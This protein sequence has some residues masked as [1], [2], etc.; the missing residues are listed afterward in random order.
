MCYCTTITAAAACIKLVLINCL[1]TVHDASANSGIRSASYSAHTVLNDLMYSKYKVFPTS[2]ASNAIWNLRSHISYC[3]GNCWCIWFG[4]DC[5]Q[6][7]SYVIIVTVLCEHGDPIVKKQTL[8]SSFLPLF[9]VRLRSIR[10]V[11]LSRF[12]LSVCPS[13]K[14]VYCDKT[15]AP[16]EKSSIMTN[17]K[18]PTSFPM[19]L[20]WTLYVAVN[21]SETQS[22]I[23]I[24]LI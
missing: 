11:L 17:R 22:M 24:W 23:S 2:D 1:S 12:C 3:P 20:R 18:S 13:V 21:A 7:A 6:Y 5:W 14:C 8:C 10:T 4:N 9:T 16:S 15:K 19:S